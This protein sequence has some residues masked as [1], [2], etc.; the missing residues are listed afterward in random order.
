MI[1]VSEGADIDGL[2]S[3][4]RED[5]VDAHGNIKIEPMKLALVMKDA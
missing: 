5:D 4:L 1:A 2:G 3:H